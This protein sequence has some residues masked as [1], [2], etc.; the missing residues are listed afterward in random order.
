MSVRSLMLSTACGGGAGTTWRHVGAL[1]IA[2]TEEARDTLRELM[3]SAAQRHMRSGVS[4]GVSLSGGLDSCAILACLALAGQ[5][6]ANL[7]CVPIDF[8][9]DLSEASALSRKGR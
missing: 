9:D 5:I 3:R 6:D 4:V 2:G 1:P 7:K 8:G